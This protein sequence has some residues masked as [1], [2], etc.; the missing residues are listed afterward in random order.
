M[1]TIIF[2]IVVA[3]AIT[4]LGIWACLISINTKVTKV[5]GFTDEQWED[6][7]ALDNIYRV[8]MN[9]TRFVKNE[10]QRAS[11]ANGHFREQTAEAKAALANHMAT[12]HADEPKPEDTPAFTNLIDET[13]SHKVADLFSALGVSADEIA[14]ATDTIEGEVTQ[15]LNGHGVTVYH[16]EGATFD[17]HGEITSLL[18]IPVV[19]ESGPAEILPDEELPFDDSDFGTY[20]DDE[21]G[22][23]LE[24]DEPTRGIEDVELPDVHPHDSSQPNDAVFP[25]Q[26]RP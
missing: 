18:G 1:Q 13:A 23:N 24:D 7:L 19:A 9:L 15:I 12:C 3:I 16:N 6:S 10:Y 22:D 21:E 4:L 26:V 17:E 14:K 2:I 5:V 25:E 8:V 11:A 20:E